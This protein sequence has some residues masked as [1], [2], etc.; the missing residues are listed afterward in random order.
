M[1]L[2]ERGAMPRFV[3]L[4][5][6][7]P[8]VVLEGPRASGKT[9]IG[10]VLVQRGLIKSVV[11]LSDPTVS[12]AAASSSTSFVEA[13]QTP[14]FI[15]EAQLVP[16]LS[17][18]IK[19]RVD[20][21]GQPGLFVLTGSSRLGRA[22]LGGSDPLAGRSA[23]LRLWP[24]T[25]GEL[26]GTPVNVVEQLVRGT[27]AGLGSVNRL[28]P[29]ELLVRMQR[30]GFPTLAGVVGQGSRAIQQQLM[31]EYV[32]GVLFHE[33]GQRHDRAELLRLF[34][35]LASTTSR[36]LNISAV[37]NELGATRETIQARLASLDGAFLTHN[38]AAHRSG[39]H[40]TMTAHPKVHACDI[41][42]AAWAARAETVPA[43]AVWGNLVETFVVNE[44]VAQAS[45]CVDEVIVRHWRD[46][47]KKV[48]VDAVLVDSGGRCVPVE[49]KAAAD[50]RPDDLKGLQAFLAGHPDSTLGVIFYSGEHV[51]PM[52]DNIWAVPISALWQ[53]SAQS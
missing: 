42:L 39:E 28:E 5:A 38:L 49:I 33:V 45:W 4:L 32:E 46:T 23:R 17:L 20:R 29:Q 24:M 35:Y 26:F 36:L 30:G 9:A 34:R 53:S 21:V 11:D 2:L 1:D 47:A 44:L 12:S 31:R 10:S 41:G 18:A 16:E 15:D 48:E 3:E 52:A 50:I 40:R 14:A 27:P 6:A 13:L 8:V 7:V 43:A 51:L 19:R 25:Q 22:Q 37:A